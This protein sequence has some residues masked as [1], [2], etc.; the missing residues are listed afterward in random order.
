MSH[1]RGG[2]SID[3]VRSRT[4]TPGNPGPHSGMPQCFRNKRRWVTLLT[5]AIAGDRSLSNSASML[6]RNDRG[7]SVFARR[8]LS[9]ARLPCDQ[10]LDHLVCKPAEVAGYAAQNH[11][12]N[13]L[14]QSVPTIPIWLALS[15][16]LPR[17]WT[18]TQVFFAITVIL[19]LVGW[20]TLGREVRG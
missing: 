11:A 9:H 2:S 16:A 12:E 10:P 17:D 4:V 13:E 18:P 14:L 7:T 20:T 19:S 5:D 8:Q 1:G 3:S 15:A 6:T